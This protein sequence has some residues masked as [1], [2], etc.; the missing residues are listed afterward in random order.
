MPG[1][2]LQFILSG[3]VDKFLTSDPQITFFKIVYR[4]Y[5]NFSIQTI[6]NNIPDPDFDK[7]FSVKINPLGDL[8]TKI[9][10]KIK[11]AQV[12]PNKHKFAW[13]RR[14]GHAII[15]QIDI[16][17][18]GNIL[19]KYHNY[20][21]DI[22]YELT[23]KSQNIKSYNKLI[24]DI[25]SLTDFNSKIKPEYNLY[26]PLI[27]WF[28]RYYGLS[29]PI[30]ALKYHDIYLNIHLE[31][32]TKLIITDN[33]CDH[34]Y[35]QIKIL[36][37][38]ILINYIYLDLDERRRFALIPHEYL[39]EQTQLDTSET[40]SL[41]FDNNI[42]KLPL[43]LTGQTKEIIFFL[44]N[45]DFYSNKPFLLYTND[46]DWSLELIQATKN[47]L[48]S[49]MVLKKYP[50]PNFSET[51]YEKFEPGSK[52][53]PSKKNNLFITNLSNYP[54]FINTKSLI[55][56]FPK[57]YNLINNIIANIIINKNNKIIIEKIYNPISPEI[58]SI[59]LEPE[60]V[61][62]TRF[63][64]YLIYINQF[65]NYGLY[66]TNTTNP[67]NFADLETDG[68]KYLI[69]KNNGIF[70]GILQPYINHTASPPDGINLYSWAL[71]P[72][73]WQPSGT[74]NFSG[75]NNKILNIYTKYK[76]NNSKLF[77]FGKSYNILRILSGFSGLAY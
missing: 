67:I 25:N 19:D 77:V 51:K 3:Q 10:I 53:K 55:Y 23:K 9:Y 73:N 63:D 68:N 33:I 39:I 64:K 56:L 41:K 48:I 65:N 15:S 66:I 16:S 30:I 75:F 37:M 58:A 7:K 24:G 21:L 13:I 8:I 61:L 43:N 28:N 4:R 22:W 57:K 38:D 69:S 74:A 6:K 62:D 29:L 40:L 11:L 46:S 36:N 35:S 34:I 76:L 12:I 44:K 42:Y 26:I 71:Y 14:L 50:D 52:N 60:F 59:P 49:S 27:F 70:F 72:E 54:L 20:W 17:I 47:I 18:G 45:L 2:L 32:K 31:N 5:T 1:G